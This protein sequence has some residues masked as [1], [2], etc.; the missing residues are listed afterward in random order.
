MSGISY[1]TESIGEAFFFGIP[2]K[3]VMHITSLKGM[4]ITSLKG[5]KIKLF[6]NSSAGLSEAV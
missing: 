3:Y 6:E 5:I 1:F 2:G 4:H